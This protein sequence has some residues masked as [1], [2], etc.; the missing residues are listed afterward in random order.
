MI[1]TK[2]SIPVALSLCSQM[3]VAGC[4]AQKVVPVRTAFTDSEYDR[5]SGAGPCTLEGQAFLT[6]RGG[7]VKYAAGR[8]VTLIPYTYYLVEVLMINRVPGQVADASD[9]RYLATM[10]T[11]SADG[12]G[13][14]EFRNIPCGEYYLETTVTWEVVLNAYSTS[15]EGGLVTAHV[16]VSERESPKKVVL[17]W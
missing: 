3:L 14:F 16:F 6:T 12:E 11:V 7:D 17:T 1:A 4:A 9:P 2:I 15:I 8:K 5:Y 10:R 13:E